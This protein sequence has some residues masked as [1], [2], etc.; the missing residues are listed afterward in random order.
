[1]DAKITMSFDQNVIQTAKEFALRNGIRLSKLTYI[2]L[3]KVTTGDYTS[4]EDL[5]IS[6]W[7]SIMVA[8]DGAVHLTKKKT[9]KIL[10]D[11]FFESCK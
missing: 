10:K 11:E 2:L 9:S 1:M 3:H 6:D 8:E 4:I 7:V 5:P